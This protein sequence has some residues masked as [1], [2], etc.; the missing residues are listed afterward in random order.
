MVSTASLLPV[1]LILTSAALH[2]AWNVAVRSHRDKLAATAL[3]VAGAVLLTLPLA[4]TLGA[5]DW[6][7]ALPWGICAG[8]G[9]AVYFVT[10][11]RAL[12]IGPLAAVYTISRGSSMLL[13]W[14]ASHL[15]L[16]EAFGWR[17]LTAV[18]FLIAGLVLLAPTDDLGSTTRGSTTRAGYGWALVC[19]LCIAAFQLIYKG[20]VADGSAPPLIFLISM[21]TSLPMV[22][23][24]LGPRRKTALRESL[25]DHPGLVIFGAASMTASFLIVLYILRT[26][27]AGWVMT[28]RNCSVAFAQI[29][30][31][32][33][34]RERPTLRSSVGVSLVLVDTLL[35]GTA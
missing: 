16:G 29:F 21:A 31:W 6:R 14:P 7:H 27:G 11:A 23:L 17:A 4:L 8:L 33:L 19:G 1:F 34:L 13:V 18:A 32:T 25:G 9:E 35:L 26:H 2:A 12:D 10:L 22:V 3:M 15:L 5:A 30:G 24:S 20:A 28:L